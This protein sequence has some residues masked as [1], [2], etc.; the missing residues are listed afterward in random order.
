M[1][2]RCWYRISHQN[3]LRLRRKDSRRKTTARGGQ[4]ELH[5]SARG[6]A[7]SASASG[8]AWGGEQRSEK[9]GFGRLE[10]LSSMA[11]VVRSTETC[12]EVDCCLDVN[13]VG[14]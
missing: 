1:N 3:G 2:N 7:A 12:L 8:G 13:G 14:S 4:T 6:T 11:G 5:A 10:L 9:L